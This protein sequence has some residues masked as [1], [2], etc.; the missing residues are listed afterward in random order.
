MCMVWSNCAVKRL[1]GSDAGWKYILAGNGCIC[2]CAY[3]FFYLVIH[4]IKDTADEIMMDQV[5]FTI[6]R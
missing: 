2:V 6:L 3:L 5:V 1:Y 4:K